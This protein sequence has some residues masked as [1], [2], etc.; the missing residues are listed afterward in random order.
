MYIKRRR[1]CVVKLHHLIYLL[2]IL[3]MVGCASYQEKPI[4]KQQLIKSWL[5]LD[6]HEATKTLESR[7]K[8]NKKIEAAYDLRDGISLN[9]AE[10][11]ALFFNPS[12]WETRIRA[13]IPRVEK[14]YARL[15]EDP[16]LNVDGEYIFE[17]VDK[18]FLIGSG[19]SVTVPL[20]GRTK[21][22]RDLAEAKLKEG[23]IILLGEEWALKT[24]VRRAWIYLSLLNEK[25]LLHERFLKELDE[26]IQLSPNYRAAGTATV[27]DERR[28]QIQHAQIRDVID[29]LSLKIKQ[30]KLQLLSLMGLHPDKNW[31]LEA[32][33][34][35]V[36]EMINSEKHNIDILK[37][38]EMIR[39]LSAY[40]V[41]QQ[42]LHMEYRRQWP[43]L[44]IGFGP[45]AEDGNSKV[46]FGLGLFPIPVWNSNKKAIQSAELQREEKAMHVETTLQNLVHRRVKAINRLDTAK[47][48]LANNHKKLLPLVEKQVS[49][50]RQFIRLGQSDLFKLADSIEQA[51]GSRMQLLNIRADLLYAQLELQILEGPFEND[52][53]FFNRLWSKK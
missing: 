9:E 49:D 40:E 34:K 36:E 27:V 7:L 22:A 50:I 15:W 8:G 17:N 51:H 12:L 39:V 14:K 44:S 24:N 33:L 20:S 10:T 11:T 1:L 41:S 28:L 16:S 5:S 6:R 25:V 45:G 53:P 42:K 18:P 47:L 46:G 37:H 19:L 35:N 29:Q 23:E 13:G 3:F 32:S 21:V 48:R 2:A 31:V 52:K 43:D 26:L 30:Q 38:P 4:E